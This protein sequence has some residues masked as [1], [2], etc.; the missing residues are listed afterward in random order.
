[1][2]NLAQTVNVLQALILT[3][4]RQMLLTPTYHVFDLYKVHHDAKYLPVQINSTDYEMGN[5]KIPSIN[6]SA[7]K[8]SSGVIHISL[9]NL[10]PNN[11]IQVKVGLDGAA[12]W[13]TV[14][15]QIVTSEKVNDINTF[16]KPNTIQL[17]KFSSARKD[18]N[19]LVVDLPSKSVVVL[20]LK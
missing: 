8:D 1:M 9:V 11:N 6:A 2:A 4:G 3:K 15:G 13:N 7:S 12:N 16:E 5:V 10:N 17:V 18:G 14:T 19:Q 20:E